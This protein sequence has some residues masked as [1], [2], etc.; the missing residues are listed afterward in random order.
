MTIEGETILCVAP[1]IWDSL[2]RESQ[3]IMSR[4]AQQNRVF[5]FEPGR[6][7]DRPAL[8]E[9]WRN[10]PNY[11]ALRARQ[12]HEHLIVIPTPSRLPFARRH[13]P[14]AALQVTTPLAATINSG[15]LARHIRWAMRQFR[16]EAPI[17]WLNESYNGLV[18]KFGEKIACYF[19]YD[20]F[21]DFVY[22]APIRDLLRAADDRLTREVDV[23]FATS[24]AQWRQR[25]AINPNTYFIPNGVDFDLFNRALAED[26]ALPSDIADLHG[27]IIGFAGW[28]G[29]HIDVELLYRVAM[30]YPKCSLALV[31]PDELPDTDSRRKLRALSN[32]FFLGQ[33][34]REELPGYLRAFDVAL[35]PWVLS[36]GHV[37]SAYPLKLHEYLAAGRSIVAVDLPE[38]QPF[39]GMLRIGTTHDEFVRQISSALHDTAPEAIAARVRIA[40][41]NTWDHRVDEIYRVLDSHLATQ[42]QRPSADDHATRSDRAAACR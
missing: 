30:A 37:R 13:L 35:M 3:Q 19:N 12:I 18:G 41:E 2:W 24:Q 9:W 1:R 33:K 34:T 39:R 8:G 31:G 4:I 42:Q 25:K 27:P 32:V 29:Y 15:L 17:L 28:L 11:F 40:R 10:A 6:D 36:S 21:P 22:N 20:E 5:Y 7:Y 14:R 23:V 16:I 26:Q 38:L